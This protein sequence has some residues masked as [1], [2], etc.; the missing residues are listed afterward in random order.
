M[1]IFGTVLIVAFGLLWSG[2]VAALDTKLLIELS[3]QF[4][5]GTFP[6]VTGQITH[7]E[8]TTRRGSK[9]GVLY[10][11]RISYQYVVDDK[12]FA[13]GKFRYDASM[14]S[15]GNRWSYATVASHPVV[16]PVKVFYNP[17]DP[18]DAVLSPGIA[19]EDLLALLFIAPFNFIAVV[20]WWLPLAVAKQEY[21][22]QPA[23]GVQILQDPPRIRLR[24][25][26]HSP[27]IALPVAFG[28]CFVG[29]I[30][31][32]LISEAH[33][34]I[35]LMTW[36]WGLIVGIGV[37]VFVWRWK[38]IRSGV[39]DL[40]IDES[41][42]TITLPM[43]CGRKSPV[44]FRCSDVEAVTV[45]KVLRQRSRGRSSYWFCPTLNA[46][47]SG[48]EAR[49]AQWTSETRARA[50]CEWLRERLQV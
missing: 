38:R 22:V 9:G 39:E 11:V 46:R 44:E 23:G 37:A 36:V 3:K 19:G 1:K 43:T 24:L 35:L 15:S 41:N 20:I 50:F 10:G 47:P 40:V 7:S 17:T 2:V 21:S 49:L 18:S 42:G 45:E 33:P 32:S 13:G 16:S 34:S 5:S 8:V 48:K 31:V 4:N 28:L 12:P 29:M 27:W 30:I 6:S 25:P 14:S 26:T